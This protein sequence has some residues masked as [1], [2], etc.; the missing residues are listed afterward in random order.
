MTALQLFF[1]FLK[2]HHF[3][4]DYIMDEKDSIIL[5]KGLV[6]LITG[7]PSEFI[8]ATDNFH[9]TLFHYLAWANVHPDL[10]QGILEE[11]CQIFT[12]EGSDFEDLRKLIIMKD[13]DNKT[14]L[15]YAL[16]SK[17]KAQPENIMLLLKYGARFDD[18]KLM[19]SDVDQLD[20]L[21]YEV[22]QTLAYRDQPED[23]CIRLVAHLR[24]QAETHKYDGTKDRFMTVSKELE[25]LTVAMLGDA[26][27]DRETFQ[28]VSEDHFNLAKK[29]GLKKYL[30][31]GGAQQYVNR[32]WYG[33]D[34]SGDSNT[35]TND[36][37]LGKRGG[38]F[39]Y[40]RLTRAAL[41]GLHWYHYAWLILLF[42][43]ENI[44]YF[45]SLSLLANR[46]RILYVP[47]I[48]YGAQ[49][50]MFSLF[51]ALLLVR[52]EQYRGI[53]SGFS[54]GETAFEGIVLAFCIGYILDKV[55][56]LILWCKRRS[57]L[58]KHMG[59]VKEKK[60][61]ALKWENIP[62]VT[63]Y[64]VD[65]LLILSL[66]GFIVTDAYV[67]SKSNN[68]S[69]SNNS[70]QAI[71]NSYCRFLAASHITLGFGAA[72]AC[73]NLLII[74]RLHSSLGPLQ[75]AFW[76]L[77]K[78]VFYFLVMLSTFGIAFAALMTSTYQAA[79]TKDPSFDNRQLS[80]LFSSI[81]SLFWTL[82]GLLDLD[83]FR[84]R[85][86]EETT[87]LYIFVAAWLLL[88]SV[89]LLN[90]LIG[91]VTLAFESIY[92]NAEQEWKY[93]R[94]IVIM[95]LE[96]GRVFPLPFGWFCIIIGTLLS[97]VS[98]QMCKIQEDNS[99]N[100]GVEM[101]ERNE[102]M[103][104]KVQLRVKQRIREAKGKSQCVR[105]DIDEVVDRIDGLE[106]R[107]DSVQSNIALMGETLETILSLVEGGRPKAVSD[108]DVKLEDEQLPPVRKRLPTAYK[109]P[110]IETSSLALVKQ[111]VP[112]L[113]IYASHPQFTKKS[114]RKLKKYVTT[115]KNE[116][117][118]DDDERSRD[119]IT[120]A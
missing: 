59:D 111:C 68:V 3:A 102:E 31:S 41:S 77:G 34:V 27:N 103:F 19:I 51:V 29:R 69:C 94:A 90:M 97:P 112:S 11:I 64:I 2:D 70:T 49:S 16:E 86:G 45:F 33:L 113:Q 56:Y 6:S 81:Q 22:T 26:T 66:L 13:D 39:L 60:S 83:D 55:A 73:L 17:T 1:N 91:L 47:A 21:L 15:D 93:T 99:A 115:I 43:I 30:A 104:G 28:L 84:T 65:A 79:H 106:N 78:D 63:G 42:Y 96:P 35:F 46:L 75:L 85:E 110:E 24:E 37:F 20:A 76:T 82:F 44:L 120:T 74:F 48:A 118:V 88:A 62:L 80:S 105:R 98:S 100:G 38:K 40:S 9:R 71:D 101:N 10:F 114:V 23:L 116:L 32:K 8:F 107:L 108:K 14:A 57:E 67:L 54:R 92:E 95:D 53:S 36:L 72:F 61:V 5:Q 117:T 87:L 25:D 18:D 4:N 7:C 109:K 58:N 119:R 52:V 12:S 89:I 50:L